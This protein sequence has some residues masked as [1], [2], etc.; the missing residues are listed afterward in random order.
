MVGPYASNTY[1][2]NS[3]AESG[4]TLASYSKENFQK[5]GI[6]GSHEETPYVF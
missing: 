6:K 2:D 3:E 1:A 4:Q 5:K